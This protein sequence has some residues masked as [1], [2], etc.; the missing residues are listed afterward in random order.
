MMMMMMLILFILAGVVGSTTV[1]L[2]QPQNDSSTIVRNPHFVW[3]PS[4]PPLARSPSCEY[5][6]QLSTDPNFPVKSTIEAR[7]PA[8]ISRFVPADFPLPPGSYWWR[9]GVAKLPNSAPTPLLFSPARILHVVPP[10][11]TFHISATASFA[12]MQQTFAQANNLPFSLVQFEPE[13]RLLDPQNQTIFINL[14]NASNVLIDG[15]NST[16]IFSSFLTYINLVNCTQIQIQNFSFD[17]ETL[18]YSALRVTAV[19]QTGLYF[20]ALLEPNHPKLDSNPFL[21]KYGIGMPVDPRYPRVQRGAPLV[22]PFTWK[23]LASLNGTPSYRFLVSSSSVRIL[24]GNVFV[25]DPRIYL[26]F[27]I[28]H[29]EEIVFFSLIAHAI[30]NEGFQSSH[31]NAMSILHSGIRLLPGRFIAANNG[32]HN[33][34]SEQ[35]GPW[36][37][38]G[39]YENTGDDIFNCN[40]LLSSVTAVNS[41][42][43]VTISPENVDPVGKQFGV[44]YKVNDTILFYNYSSGS[45]LF[46]RTIVK[47]ERLD[48]PVGAVLVTLNASIGTIQPGHVSKRPFDP[49]IT[50]V[51]NQ[52]RTCD[53]LVVRGLTIR[54]GRRVGLLVHGKRALIENNSFE[55]L[56]GGFVEAWNDPAEG[57]A[58]HSYIIRNNK[59]KD[60]NQLDRVAAPI[61]TTIFGQADTQYHQDFLITNNTISSGPGSTF[62]LSRINGVDLRNNTITRCLT[63]PEQ[64]L[65][66]TA[67]TDIVFEGSNVIVNSTA[68]EVCEKVVV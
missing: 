58:T 30:S 5:L 35:F 34:H 8:V 64:V 40:Q 42:T 36:L 53:Q 43:Q 19:N 67:T 41:S 57:F 39:V 10:R 54:N 14:V 23:Q 63:D 61:W 49:R 48:T 27:S 2:L 18:P 16:L 60:I 37:E 9:V 7:L 47:A 56:G 15:G 11:R 52:R 33:H 45:I 31:T 13:T 17:F 62:L 46:V 28:C 68:R 20:D 66:L 21:A 59:V 32:G 50:Q 26:G 24:V 51:F 12:D 38:G 29:C 22:I 6:I 4:C 55:G 25:I 3:Q 44:D 1:Q 65:N